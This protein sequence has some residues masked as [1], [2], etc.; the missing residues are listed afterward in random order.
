MSVQRVASSHEVPAGIVSWV[1]FEALQ[2]FTHHTSAVVAA[3]GLFWLV[4]WMV[5]RMLHD[6]AM[7]RAVLLIDEVVLVCIFVYFG[8]E[9]LFS[10]YLRTKG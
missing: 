4:G 1:N 8:Y 5:R 7:K 10:L 2:L 9:L 6:S 3:V